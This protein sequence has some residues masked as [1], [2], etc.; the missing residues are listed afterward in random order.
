MLLNRFPRWVALCTVALG[1][2]AVAAPPLVAQVA[3]PDN[4]PRTVT[5]IVTPTQS[6]P[7]G[8]Q[9]AA[10]NL[11][12]DDSYEFTP[13][14]PCRIVD[15]R[16]AALGA[17]TTGSTRN[18]IVSAPA[19]SNLFGEQGGIN[20]GLTNRVK[21]VHVNVTVV[22]GNAG[23]LTMYPADAARPNASVVNF[24][25][26]QTVANA[27]TVPVCGSCS[28]ADLSVFSISGPNHVVID[29]MGFYTAP[30]VAEVAETGIID[31][32]TAGIS[33]RRRALGEYQIDFE[34]DV[35]DCVAFATIGPSGGGGTLSGE[36]WTAD[37]TGSPNAVFVKTND[38][39]GAVADRPFKIR[40][41]C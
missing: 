12:I 23:H 24:V 3:K 41:V 21:A 35:T 27:F 10:G 36:I 1:S 39:A 14:T 29:V 38:S 19:G 4:T 5:P 15:T 25:G 9:A 8:P 11:A 33:A 2:I 37:R 34:R 31:R 6:S 30:L 26:G 13:V 20:C 40:L 16:T 7:D 32:S 22:A 17:L 18:V 28:N